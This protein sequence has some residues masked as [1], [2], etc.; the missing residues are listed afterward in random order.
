MDSSRLYDD[1]LKA[2]EYLKTGG[3]VKEFEIIQEL[4]DNWHRE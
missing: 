2:V 4:G 3:F 1:A